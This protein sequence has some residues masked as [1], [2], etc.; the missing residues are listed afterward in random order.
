MALNEAQAVVVLMT[1]DEITYLRREYSNG[2]QDP[3]AQPA[4]QARPNVLFEAGMALGR[5]PDR[6]VLVELGNLRPFSDIAGR[7]VLR[8]RNDSQSRQELARRLT[9]A[10]CRVDLTGSD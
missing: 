3:D 1:P 5:N 4:A 6:T 7:H 9:T 8:M 2:D 10:G